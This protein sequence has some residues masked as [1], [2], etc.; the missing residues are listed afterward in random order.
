MQWSVKVIRLAVAANNRYTCC[1]SLSGQRR[2]QAGLRVCV[3]GVLK[4]LGP[5]LQGQLPVSSPTSVCLP[6]LPVPLARPSPVAMPGC[7][8]SAAIY[9]SRAAEAKDKQEIQYSSVC[10]FSYI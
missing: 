5:V 8:L 2:R 7:K 1:I 4:S 10:L 3:G 6:P 9:G